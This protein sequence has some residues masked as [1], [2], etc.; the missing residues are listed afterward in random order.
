MWLNISSQLEVSRGNLAVTTA[1]WKLRLQHCLRIFQIDS[2]EPA[3]QTTITFAPWRQHICGKRTHVQCVVHCVQAHVQCRNTKDHGQAMSMKVSNIQSL[4]YT[5]ISSLWTYN[6]FRL[7][8]AISRVC[9]VYVWLNDTR[10]RAVQYRCTTKLRNS[11][12]RLA[13]QV[14]NFYVEII[15]VGCIRHPILFLS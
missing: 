5:Y 14:I 2:C 12:T 7:Y 8:P 1:Y 15:S 13:F 10:I 11:K 6:R 3:S 4:P 9:I